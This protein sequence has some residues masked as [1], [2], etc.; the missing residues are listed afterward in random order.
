VVQGVVLS[1]LGVLLTV[2]VDLRGWELPGGEPEP[3]ESREEALV[4]EVR[5]ETGIEVE[6][7]RVTG[8][9]HRSGFLPHV[10][11]V[12]RCRP[13]GGSLAPSFETPEVRW[14]DPDALPDTFF[15]W[16]RQPLR[17]GLSPGEL[18]VVRHERQGLSAILA[19]MCIDLRM[20]FSAGEHP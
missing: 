13:V 18:P 8:E 2:R 10:A 15:P 3:G 1:E 6:V 20:R 11:Y 9:Y 14:W 19:G 5:E 4:R 12:Y 7:E 16:Y 17:D